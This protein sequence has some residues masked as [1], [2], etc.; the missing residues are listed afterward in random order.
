MALEESG[1]RVRMSRGWV[2][3]TSAGGAPLCVAESAVQGLL[4]TVPLLAPLKA[5][6]RDALA[7]KI[8]AVEHAGS[9]SVVVQ[10]EE[11]DAMYFVEEGKCVAYIN[12]QRVA[13][14]MRGDFFGEMALVT[15]APRAATIR[16]VGRARL[17]KI[18]YGAFEPQVLAKCGDVLRQ[19]TT[20]YA[21]QA[22]E[23]TKQQVK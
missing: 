4:A 10:G 11:G 12:R 6:E 9:E 13:E 21:A 19:R 7:A 14:Y 16:A 18:G 3:L 17:L 8:E 2:S 22:T 15:K 20:L 1:N 5:A 23:R